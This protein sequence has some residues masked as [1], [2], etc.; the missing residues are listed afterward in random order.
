MKYQHVL[1]RNN[2][3][4]SKLVTF[5]LESDLEQNTKRTCNEPEVS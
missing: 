3:N 2:H 4:N 5:I 1:R